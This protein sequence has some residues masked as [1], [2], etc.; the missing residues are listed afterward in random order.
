MNATETKYKSPLE[1]AFRA[2]VIAGLGLSEMQTLHHAGGA[3]IDD[4]WFQVKWEES[5]DEHDQHGCADCKVLIRRL[6]QSYL[7]FCLNRQMAGQDNG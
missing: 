5:E 4:I 7:A 1:K 6:L 2:G 3:S